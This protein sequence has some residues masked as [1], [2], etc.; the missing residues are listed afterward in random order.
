MGLR[1]RHE[2]PVERVL[3]DHRQPPGP[4]PVRSGDGETR[5]RKVAH[6]LGKVAGAFQQAEV[7]REGD[8]PG[9]DG[10]DVYGTGGIEEVFGLLGQLR[11]IVE[12]P[13]DHGGVE[14]EAHHASP[15]AAEI[16]A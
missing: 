3:V 14:E 9:R 4:H 2:Q 11:G 8:L 13:E 16:P 12:P 6:A 5:E 10:A 7:L 15:K 1:L